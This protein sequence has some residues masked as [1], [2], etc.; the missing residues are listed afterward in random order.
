MMSV[1]FGLA[2]APFAARR[3]PFFFPSDQH[4]RALEFMG[5]SLWTNARLGVVTADHG[6]RKTADQTLLKDLDGASSPP[7]STRELPRATSCRRSCASSASRSK[8]PT[9]PIVAAAGALHVAPGE[10]GSHLPARHRNPQAMHPSVLEEL[11]TLAAAEVDGVRVL[12]VLLL[13]SL[14]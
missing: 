14:R 8:R 10:H 11:R 5:H 7:R 3:Q 2:T 13:S 6:C 1:G 9:R 4:L 12:K